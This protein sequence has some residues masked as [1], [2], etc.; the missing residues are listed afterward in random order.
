[1]ATEVESIVV[2]CPK[3]GVEFATWQGIGLEGLGPDPCPKCGFTP[4]EDPRVYWDRPI[5]PPDEDEAR[6]TG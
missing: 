4:S 2:M 5:E 6:L 1:M 3:C